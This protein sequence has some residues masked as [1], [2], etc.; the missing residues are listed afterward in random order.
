MTEKLAGRT[1]LKAR[2]NL[3][4]GRYHRGRR[5][6]SDDNFHSP[7]V[8]PPST[9]YKASIMKRYHRRRTCSHTSPRRLPTM[10]MLHDARFVECRWW[11][12]GWTVKPVIIWRSSASMIPAPG[13]KQARGRLLLSSSSPSCRNGYDLLGIKNNPDY[14]PVIAAMFECSSIDGKRKSDMYCCTRKVYKHF[15]SAKVVCKF[16]HKCIGTAPCW[17]RIA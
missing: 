14:N 17:Q 1:L 13:N 8:S 6:S 15:D 10:V 12:D 11:N 4:M 5:P 16:T 7:T 3:S 2:S 9:L